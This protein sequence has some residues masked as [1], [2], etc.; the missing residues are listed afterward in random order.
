MPC[1]HLF[2][3]RNFV[4]AKVDYTVSNEILQSKLGE[5]R[6]TDFLKSPSS[7][8]RGQCTK[9]FQYNYVE[10]GDPSDKRKPFPISNH[11]S[12]AI[13]ITVEWIIYHTES[14][15]VLPKGFR[16]LYDAPFIPAWCSKPSNPE[17]ALWCHPLP[18]PQEVPV[19]GSSHRDPRLAENRSTQRP[20]HTFQSQVS[21]TSP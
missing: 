6:W 1:T 5:Y 17:A 15:K 8:E 4:I 12:M 14:E 9:L 7:E 3:K 13:R 10:F 18:V 19:A 20:A 16:V 2:L 21:Q 11:N